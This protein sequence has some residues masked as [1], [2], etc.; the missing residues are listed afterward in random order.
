[1]WKSSRPIGVA[2]VLIDEGNIRQYLKDTVNSYNGCAYILDSK[3][4][5]ISN[6]N[7]DTNFIIS[8]PFGKNNYLLKNINDQKFIYVWV[9]SNK[10]GW[11]YVA[12]LP[13]KNVMKEV[14]YIKNVT[15]WILIITLIVGLLI[16][17]LLSKRY[18]RPLKDILFILKSFF[19][20][21]NER[22]IK[23]QE[24]QFIKE[25][26]ADLITNH[27]TLT[28][29]LNIQSITIK[30]IVLER[31]L[32]GQFEN[33]KNIN[34]ML[35][36]SQL[37]LNGK[38][39]LVAVIR[40]IREYELVSKKILKEL[41]IFRIVID[42]ILKKQEYAKSLTQ[43]LNENE[44]AIIFSFEDGNL[45]NCHETALN[46][47]R[48][49]E[50]EI[51]VRYFIHPIIGVGRIYKN[52]SDIQ[53]SFFEAKYSL[54]Y[55]EN[56]SNNIIW[57]EESERDFKI[58]YYPIEL[59]EKIINLVVSGNIDG[60]R[61]IIDL[62]IDENLNKKKIT[63]KMQNILVS[64]MISTLLK[65]CERSNYNKGI[66]EIINLCS[67][68]DD[69]HSS[70]EQIKNLMNKICEHNNKSKKCH[71]RKLID[72]ILEFIQQN[73]TDPNLSMYA[74][75][76]NFNLS[77]SY[78]SYFFKEQVK[79]KFSDYLEKLRINYAIKLLSEQVYTIDE[80]AKKCGYISAHTFRRAFKRV[81]GILPSEYYSKNNI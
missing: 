50:Q 37:G 55:Y 80:I 24:Y 29:K 15:I 10:N 47:L 56:E 79:D 7:T 70:F 43:V 14:Y 21:S 54:D 74:I 69:I 8:L 40:I 78:F 48:N 65:A 11:R 17:L 67:K 44:I 38:A 22:E 39:Y 42:E 59:E 77:E 68:K 4:N 71:N 13:L 26:I 76:K 28:E 19:V 36:Y 35:K 5:T 62:I 53:F 30:N 61:S 60:V 73:Y 58:I 64:E 66:D 34:T 27:K 3:G 20:S 51:F 33:E 12:V 45:D 41:D 23:Y 63:K 32:N 9:K 46:I 57:Y 16:S 18:E 49:L 72:Q 2:A 31:L 75:A 6:Y 1:M 81:T 52:I 25:K